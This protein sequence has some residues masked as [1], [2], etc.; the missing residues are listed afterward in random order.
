MIT[1]IILWFVESPVKISKAKL[2]RCRETLKFPWNKGNDCLDVSPD[3]LAAVEVWQLL[4]RNR[5]ELEI[6]KTERENLIAYATEASKKGC[7]S[8]ITDE[9]IASIKSHLI[10]GHEQ[11]TLTHNNEYN[12][13]CDDEFEEP[14]EES[15]VE[16]DDE[17]DDGDIA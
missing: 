13:F 16:G 2:L 1:I 10:R 4:Q 15:D 5:E 9:L 6:L 12:G 3:T 17:D 14:K 11:V 7:E 8:W